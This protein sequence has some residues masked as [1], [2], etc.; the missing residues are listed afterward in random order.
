MDPV[1]EG[2]CF[3]PPRS[4][5]RERAHWSRVLGQIDEQLAEDLAF[6]SVSGILC[7][8]EDRETGM[9]LEDAL[10]KWRALRSHGQNLVLLAK[11][12]LRAN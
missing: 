10:W 6:F 2:R 12:P 3:L 5:C 9:G 11:P 7:A 4:N 8:L 1:V